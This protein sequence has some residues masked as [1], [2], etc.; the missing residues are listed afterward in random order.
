MQ[1]TENRKS[2]SM[3]IFLCTQG[4]ST[5]GKSYLLFDTFGTIEHKK[6]SS[7]VSFKSKQWWRDP[8][9]AAYD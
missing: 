2:F 9:R 7:F 8:F 1:A 4:G 3:Q 5:Q 6:K